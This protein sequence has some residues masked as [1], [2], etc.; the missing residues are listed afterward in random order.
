MWRADSGGTPAALPYWR[1]HH[2]RMHSPRRTQA[3]CLTARVQLPSPPH[4]PPH[5]PER[6]VPTRGLTGGPLPAE[7]VEAR[8]R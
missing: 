4:A 7:P 8:D 3:P 5:P 1:P 6:G 2:C